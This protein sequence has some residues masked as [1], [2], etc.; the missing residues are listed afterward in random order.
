MDDTKCHIIRQLS[1]LEKA[2]RVTSINN[3]QHIVTA[4]AKDINEEDNYRKNR[5]AQLVTIRKLVVEL[6]KTRLDYRKRLELYTDYLQK[7]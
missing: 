3:Y 1:T 4:I 2:K 7:N 5:Q 6:E